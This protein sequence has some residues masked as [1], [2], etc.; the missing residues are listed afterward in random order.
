[1]TTNA[2]CVFEAIS[3]EEGEEWAHTRNRVLVTRR[4]RIL[5]EFYIRSAN[6]SAIARFVHHIFLIDRSIRFFSFFNCPIIPQVH[7]IVSRGAIIAKIFFK[8]CFQKKKKKRKP[9]YWNQYTF[10]TYLYIQ[11]SATFPISLTDFI[12][13]VPS[14]TE[15]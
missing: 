9:N 2:Y 11:F 14:F 6:E 10:Q 13:F 8:I 5:N 1:M 12:H 7:F 3:S 15:F 4:D